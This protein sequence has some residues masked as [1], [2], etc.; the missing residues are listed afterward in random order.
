MKKD[1]TQRSGAITKKILVA[2]SIAYDH[3]LHYHGKFQ[4]LFLP[5]QL[6]AL[7]ISFGVTEKAFFLGGCGGNISRHL[8]KLGIEPLLV[9]FAGNDFD[10]YETKLREEKISTQYLL[11]T[12][13]KSTA[14]ATIVTDDENHQLAFFNFGAQDTFRMKEIKILEK[15]LKHESPSFAI[16]SPTNPD[17][18]TMLAGW[19]Q[20]RSVPYFFDPGQAMPQFAKHDLQWL[21]KGAFGLFVN[22]YEMNMICKYLGKTPEKLYRSCQLVVETLGEKGSL[23]TFQGKTFKIP[24]YPV[25]KRFDPTGAGDAYRAGFLSSFGKP[26]LKLTSENMK[27]AGI[28]GSKFA[29]KFLSAKI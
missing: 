28:T 12:L 27:R 6:H 15:Q 2:G 4:D 22:E 14:K 11:R 9:G 25:N 19:C 3:L 21:T 20:K 1:N 26:I 18:I 29:S 16:L 5:D 7:S 13:E 24:A 17:L 10:R 8:K 23:V